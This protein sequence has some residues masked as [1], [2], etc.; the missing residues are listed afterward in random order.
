MKIFVCNNRFEDM[1]SAIYDAWSSALTCGHD[2][3]FLTC[4]PVFQESILDE[5][6]YAECDREKAVKVVRS[7]SKKMGEEALGF[8]KYASLSCDEGA[9]DAIYRFMIRGFK[10]GHG[11]TNALTE[12]AVV[13]LMELKRNVGNEAHYF[14]EFVRFSSVDN[15]VYVSHIEPKNNVLELVGMHF[16]DRMPSEHF[17][18]VD[19]GRNLAIV[20]P[21]DSQNFFRYLTDEELNLLLKTDAVRDE[22]S[23]MWKT[24]FNSIA[25]RERENRKCQRNMLPLW[26]RK[27]M[28]EFMD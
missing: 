28:I 27:H 7:V 10:I 24:F 19:D 5:Y 21:K 2:N 23:S 11:I 6:V 18:I 20:H 16:A 25:I 15:Q 22:Y 4:G 14:R 12:P 8:I 17:I 26:M 13:R 9:L 3:V 1:M